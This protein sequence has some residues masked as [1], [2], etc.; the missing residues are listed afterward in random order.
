[1]ATFTASQLHGGMK[2]NHTGPNVAQAHLHAA[3]SVSEIAFLARIPNGATI[4][5]LV[6]SGGTT[7][8][9]TGTW[10]LGFNTPVAIDNNASLSVAGLAAAISLTASAIYILPVVGGPMF[11]MR[12]SLS[13]DQQFAW[14]QASPLGSVTA[15]TTSSLRLTVNYTVPGG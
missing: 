12:I 7:G 9:T 5:S 6:L 8:N 11:P 14:I 2:M 13:D 10:S 4:H 3:L 1:M 15:T